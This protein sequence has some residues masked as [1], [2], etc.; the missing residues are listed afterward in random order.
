M[1]ALMSGIFMIGIRLRTILLNTI[2]MTMGCMLG[3]SL[4]V[5]RCA[6]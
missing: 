6:V 1:A 4:C 5:L 2:V 3:H